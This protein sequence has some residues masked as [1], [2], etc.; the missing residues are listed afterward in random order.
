[1]AWTLH[2]PEV[3]SVLMGASSVAQIEENVAAANNLS[4]TPEELA[5]IDKLTQ[6]GA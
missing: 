2:L 5:E 4:F 3:T 1:V 6:P